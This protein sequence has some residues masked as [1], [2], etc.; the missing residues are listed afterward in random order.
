MTVQYA[1]LHCKHAHNDNKPERCYRDW[2]DSVSDSQFGTTSTYVYHE[3]S[4]VAESQYS[5]S[6]RS[7]SPHKK[8]R[9]GEHVTI[10]CQTYS[11]SGCKQLL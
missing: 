9:S 4:A 11:I 7:K 8:K 1:S 10:G 6:R 5:I 2:D 3:N